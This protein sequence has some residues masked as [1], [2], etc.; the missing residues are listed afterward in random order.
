MP[1][2]RQADHVGD[3]FILGPGLAGPPKPTDGKRRLIRG[4][5]L[6]ARIS[7]DYEPQL[8]VVGEDIPG[9]A[10]PNYIGT[11]QSL[12]TVDRRATVVG[13]GFRL[14]CSDSD[15]SDDDV[16]SIGPMRPVVTAAP[17]GG[18]DG[19][20]D[21]VLQVSPLKEWSVNSWT[22]DDSCG[23]R[24]AQLDNFN[25]FIPADDR[26]GGLPVPEL[27]V[28]LPDSENDVYDVVPEQFPVQMKTMAVES[29][30]PP[31][32]AQMRPK[33]G[34]DSVLPRRMCRGRDV[35]TEDGPAAVDSRRES[36]VP[37]TDVCGGIYVMPDCITIVLPKSAAM[38]QAASV[39]AQTRPGV[40]VARTCSCRWTGVWNRLMMML[41][42]S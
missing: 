21:E 11:A 38:P 2:G 9:P 35:L 31:V 26:V 5:G 18:A 32:V 22:A 1:T 10:V 6:V 3:R 15:D 29:L 23:E 28:D 41:W 27:Q 34:C 16:L 4:E 40:A 39:V 33:G 36:I 7:N 25:W 19:H 20:D 37:D 42:M 12:E 30:C 8:P 13:R 17:L 14:P 24:C